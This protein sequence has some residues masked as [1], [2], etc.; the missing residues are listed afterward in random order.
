MKQRDL[1]LSLSLFGAFGLMAQSPFTGSLPPAEG[2]A[3]FYLYQVESG[4]WLQNNQRVRGQWTTHAQLDKNGFDVEVI[5]RDGSYQLNPKEG[6]NHSINSGGDR[7]YMDTGHGVSPW[8]FIPV[9]VAGVS[10]AFNIQAMAWDELEAP[11]LLGESNDE[12]SDN[13][14]NTTWQL[15]S[16]EERLLHMQQAAANGPV[17]ATWLIP[18]Q[19]FGRNDERRNRWVHRWVTDGGNVALNGRDFNAVQEAWH[20][21]SNYFDYIVLTGLPN[22]TYR[23]A[24]QG[25][26]RDTEGSDFDYQQRMADGT[27]VLRAKYFAGAASAPVMP[28]SKFAKS[29]EAGDKYTY[30]VEGAGLWIPNSL[31]NAAEVFSDGE[32]MNEWIEAVVTDGTLIVGI[33]KRE[34]TYRDWLVYDNFQ[35]QYVGPETPAVDLSAVKGELEALIAEAEAAPS[36]PAVTAAIAAAREAL[37]ATG[38]TDLRVAI[39]DLQN[40]L[41]G[42]QSSANEINLYNRTKELCVAEGVDTSTA[43]EKFLSAVTRDDYNSALRELRYNRR[44]AHADKQADVF[45]GVPVQEG[46]FYLYNIGQKQFLSGGSD[47]GAHA[48]LSFPGWPVTL[49]VEIPEENAYHINTNLFNGPDNHYMNYRGY[50]D[51]GKGSPWEFVPVEGKENVYNIIQYDWKDAYVVWYPYAS[52]DAGNGDETTV[53]TEQRGISP[54]DPNAQWK[55]VSRAERE[56]LLENA[57]LDNPADATFFIKSP[58]FNQR[59]GADSSWQFTNGNIWEYGANHYDFAAESWNSSDCDINQLV[60]GLPAGVYMASLQGFY[61]NGHHGDQVNLPADQNAFLYFGND[62]EADVALPNILSESGKAPG[63]GN[64]GTSEDGTVYNIPDGIVQATNF[65]K[66]GLYKTF[67]VINKEDSDDIVLGVYKEVQ[68]AEGDWVVVDN[69]RLTYYGTDTTPEEVLEMI[70]S[71]VEEIEAAAVETIGDNRTYN[72]QG[73]EVSNPT[74]PGIYIRNGKKFVVR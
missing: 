46:E 10:N 68:G 58:N 25:Y 27:E 67:T 24:V 26:Y 5:A 22:G 53:S 14:V 70:Q 37:N 60:E 64:D 63:E 65:F 28:I 59:E 48:A 52:V 11:Y 18:G 31:D 73:I 15:V 38:A 54:D 71:G 61:R 56:A 1:I 43:D 66:S 57:S 21:C 12:L 55:L 19:D 49:E 30:F 33:S 45:E 47:W 32:Y 40:V 2:S 7:L 16:R 39:F 6:N 13:P 72:L 20:Q 44:R 36:T 4:T 34:A 69:F 42:V 3:D 9:E 62:P 50:M 35:L 74:A 41:A 23:F 8:A 17:D 51:C 29:E